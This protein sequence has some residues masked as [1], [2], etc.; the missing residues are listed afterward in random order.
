M[1]WMSFTAFVGHW[2]CWD[3]RRSCRTGVRVCVCARACMYVRVHASVCV[4]VHAC[5]CAH[6]CVCMRACMYVHSMA[7]LWPCHPHILS[8]HTYMQYTY[9]YTQ[10]HCP[11]PSHSSGHPSRTLHH[12]CTF[13]IHSLTRAYTFIR[14]YAHVCIYVCIVHLYILYGNLYM[15]MNACTY[16]NS[17][18]VYICTY[19]L[20][21][22]H[23][24]TYM[25][26]R[27]RTHTQ[28]HTHTISYSPTY[29]H[30]N[31]VPP[32]PIPLVVPHVHSIRTIPTYKFVASCIATACLWPRSKQFSARQLCWV[33]LSYQ[34]TAA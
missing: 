11:T 25:Y 20:I 29:V 21:Y 10:T 15:Y 31:I 24:H 33:S 17:H 13:C 28:T 4:C 6:A 32:Y 23:V 3:W 9:V 27:I 26:V 30:I 34:G 2:P 16:I 8:A 5:V 7:C 12:M 14:V 19:I 18:T 1:K 22:T